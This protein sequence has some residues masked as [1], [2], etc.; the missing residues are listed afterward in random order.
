MVEVKGSK[1][2]KRYV[3]S[4]RQ[5]NF[6]RFGSFVKQRSCEICQEPLEGYSKFSRFCEDCKLTDRYRYAEWLPE[7]GVF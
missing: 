6:K 3:L 4:F 5:L 1:N 7:V 2:R